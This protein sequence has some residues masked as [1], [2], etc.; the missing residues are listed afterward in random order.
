MSPGLQQH[1]PNPCLYHHVTPLV[2]LHIILNLCVLV[3]VQISSLGKE[4]DC[5]GVGL[6]LTRS[7]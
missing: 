4:A 6:T 3:S 2:S 1:Q 7:F 5:M